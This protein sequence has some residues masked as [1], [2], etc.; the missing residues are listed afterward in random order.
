MTGDTL[1]TQNAAWFLP[2]IAIFCASHLGGWLKEYIRHLGPGQLKDMTQF[3]D[4]GRNSKDV[5]DL[6]VTVFTNVQGMEIYWW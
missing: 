4:T 2:F 6:E 1:D 5:P 3:S